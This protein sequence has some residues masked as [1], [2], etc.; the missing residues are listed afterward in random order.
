MRTTPL[1]F[2]RAAVNS[3]FW[4]CFPAMILIALMAFRGDE[5]AQKLALQAQQKLTA[6]HGT[7]AEALKIRKC[8]ITISEEG[9]LRYR[10]TYTS[11][12]QEY[13]S[14]NLSRLRSID[15]LGNSGSGNLIIRTMEDDIIVQ[16]YNDRSGNVDSMSVDMKINLQAIEAEDLSGLQQDLFEIKRLASRN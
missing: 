7:D 2:Q 4:R 9:F 10:K 13:Y 14:F 6:L 15:Y 11:G 5:L 12:K 8:E 3:T 1:S 16:T